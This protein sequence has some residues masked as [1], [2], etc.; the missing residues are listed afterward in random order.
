MELV[1]ASEIFYGVG[2]RAGLG[3]SEIAGDLFKT[4][5]R[6]A[7][8]R[9]DE[10]WRYAMWPDLMRWDERF[11]R[12]FYDGTKTYA[13]GDIVYNSAVDEKYYRA[14][15]PVLAFQ[16]PPNATYWE[17][18]AASGKPMDAYIPYEQIGVGLLPFGSVFAVTEL[19]PRIQADPA[20]A[21]PL[22]FWRS[23]KGIEVP[24]GIQGTLT[25]VWV[26][27]RL[28]SPK[29]FG[30]VYS[31]SATYTTVQQIYYTL[32]SGASAD[33]YNCISATTAGLNPEN[34]S[35]WAIV[36]IPRFLE[37]W[38]VQSVYADYLKADG[39][40]EK[41]MAELADAHEKLSQQRILLE[42]QEGQQE[43]MIVQTR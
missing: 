11:F 13:A 17:E 6:F 9:L 38:L 28:R 39:Q 18:V 34:S 4:L 27:Y 10:G 30:A 41:Y 36:Q 33:F 7:S 23:E 1:S 37:E 8:K 15:A 19:D 42:A 31:G 32:A 29:L 20:L 24:K 5:R 2:D 3:E 12:Q 22:E 25:T 43:R 35:K 16:T 21:R 40:D 14:I 26:E